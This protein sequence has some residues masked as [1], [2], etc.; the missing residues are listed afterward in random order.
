MHFAIH[1]RCK[2]GE[3]RGG[4]HVEGEMRENNGWECPEKHQDR[5]YREFFVNFNTNIY[6][7]Q[8]YIQIRHIYTCPDVHFHKWLST[9]SLYW[10]HICVHMCVC[11]LIYTGVHTCACMQRVEVNLRWR[12]LDAIHLVP[13]C[14]FWDRVSLCPSSRWLGSLI[15]L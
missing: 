11:E 13:I 10:L 7:M 5:I 3:W 15:G 1:F 14:L 4:E 9:Y 2:L 12:S 6:C 8:K